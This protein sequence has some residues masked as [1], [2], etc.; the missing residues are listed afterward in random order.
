VDNGI[1]RTLDVRQVPALFLA[2]PRAEDHAHR[3]WV[4]SE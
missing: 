2:E 1:A 3:L 4:L